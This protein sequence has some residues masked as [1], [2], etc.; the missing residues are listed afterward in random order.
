M[1]QDLQDQLGY[2]YEKQKQNQKNKATPLHQIFISTS[3]MYSS[4][5]SELNVKVETIKALG[6]QDQQITFMGL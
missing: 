6:T 5:F 2:P 1:L 4:R 3:K